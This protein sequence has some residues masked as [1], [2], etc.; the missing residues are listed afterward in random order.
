MK[1]GQR[2]LEQFP[3]QTI[4]MNVCQKILELLGR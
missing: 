3:P 1:G 4:D 2:F